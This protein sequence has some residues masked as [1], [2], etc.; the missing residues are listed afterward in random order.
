[1]RVLSSAEGFFVSMVED[2]QITNLF[3]DSLEAEEIK[4]NIEEFLQVIF[5]IQQDIENQSSEISEDVEQTNGRRVQR[6]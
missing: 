3:G 5:D 1:M 4:Q 6:R 2:K